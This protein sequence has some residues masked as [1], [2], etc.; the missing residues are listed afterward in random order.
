MQSK[1]A[2]ACADFLRAQPTKDESKLKATHAHELVAAYFGYRSRAALL[3][4]HSYDLGR[5]QKAELLMPHVPLV[6]QRLTELEYLEQD[7]LVARGIC[8]AL[9]FFLHSE[10]HFNGEVW[11]DASTALHVFDKSSPIT[12]STLSE[13]IQDVLDNTSASV[14]DLSIVNAEVTFDRDAVIISATGK[15]AGKAGSLRRAKVNKIDVLLTVTFPRR[16]GKTAYSFPI[17]NVDGVDQEWRDTSE[18]IPL[19]LKGERNKEHF[20]R[21]TGGHRWGESQEDFQKRQEEILR[22]RKKIKSHLATVQDV[23]DLS[24]LLGADDDDEF[25]YDLDRD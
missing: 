16:A 9:S 12:E 25:Q 17:V 6:S 24:R 13:L 15:H 2:K 8:S 22:I 7:H 18:L 21:V 4:D 11:H 19:P 23:D 14:D 5:L 10:G 20:V 1:I 3:S